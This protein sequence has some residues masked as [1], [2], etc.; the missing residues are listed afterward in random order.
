MDMHGPWT[1]WT[2]DVESWIC[3]VPYPK[4]VMKNGKIAGTN[5]VCV[6]V[7]LFRGRVPV[8]FPMLPLKYWRKVC[9]FRVTGPNWVS[10]WSRSLRPLNLLRN[11]IIAIL[12]LFKSRR[13]L[14]LLLRAILPK[15]HIFKFVERKNYVFISDCI[16]KVYARNLCTGNHSVLI[17]FPLHTLRTENLKVHK[18]NISGP[19]HTK[20]GRKFTKS[21]FSGNYSMET[22]LM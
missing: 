3:S 10:S 22:L 15:M 8:A 14:G 9:L 13:L 17:L 20:L 16:D 18:Q 2:L 19:Y 12:R 11:H 4:L 5:R 7:V 1:P 6:K 21:I